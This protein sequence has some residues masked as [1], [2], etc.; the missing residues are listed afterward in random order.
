MLSKVGTI[1]AFYL[2]SKR[3]NT[4]ANEDL[5]L[6][7]PKEDDEE[8]SESSGGLSKKLIIII[9]AVAVVVLVGGGLA[10]YFLLGSDDEAETSDGAEVSETVSEDGSGDEAPADVDEAKKKTPPPPKGDVIYVK[11]SDPFLVNVVSG[12]RTRMMQIKAQFMV[13][14]TEAEEAVNLHMPLIRNDLLDYFS[15]ADADEVRTRE[16]LKALKNGALQVAQQ[17]MKEQVGYEA[18]EMILFTGFVVQ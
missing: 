3:E 7:E 1:T 2:T 9:A 18:I 17:V 6:E 5:S 16:G 4:M 13:H 15:T 11:V 12:K 10:A 14:S 8:N